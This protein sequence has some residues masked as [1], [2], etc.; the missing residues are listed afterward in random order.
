MINFDFKKIKIIK[1]MNMKLNNNCA[2][3][4]V[5]ANQ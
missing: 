5:N 2:F 1:V 4:S 3:T